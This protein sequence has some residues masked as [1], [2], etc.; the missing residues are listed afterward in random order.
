MT[1]F[2]RAIR[3]HDIIFNILAEV[4]TLSATKEIHISA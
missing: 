2:R 4:M 3:Y 1:R